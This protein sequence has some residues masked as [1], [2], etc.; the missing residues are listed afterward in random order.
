MNERRM[1]SGLVIAL[2]LGARAA[3]TPAG[4]IEF[5]EKADWEA[6]VADFTTIDFVGFPKGTLVTD[7]YASLGALFTDGYDFIIFGAT[8]LNDGA[9]LDGGDG[10]I[11]IAFDAP[12][13][14]IAVDY[15]GAVRF[16]LFSRGELIHTADFFATGVGNFGGLI[17]SELF[18]TVVISDPF[19]PVV[20]IDDL[21]F[22][23]P[24]PGAV[25]LVA[26]CALWTGR[27]RRVP[28]ATGTGPG[29]R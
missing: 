8:F 26:A 15:A 1:L 16:E 7:Q 4:V 27:V 11:H 29:R 9:G 12:Q 13:A 6:A 22:G 21:F 20:V 3:S 25:W 28:R 2:A 17:S 19:D 5:E 24:A 18:D 14:H 10:T 23:V